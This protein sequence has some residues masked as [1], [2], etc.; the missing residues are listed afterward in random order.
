MGAGS[1]TPHP[2]TATQPGKQ[3][4]VPTDKE[5]GRV[6]KPNMDA[7]KAKIL[8]SLPRS[9]HNSQAVQPIT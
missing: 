7:Q 2:P 5:E 8:F 4:S 1:F 3:P 9:N 6:P